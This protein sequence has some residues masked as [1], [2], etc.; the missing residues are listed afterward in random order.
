MAITT[1]IPRIKRT[2]DPQLID[3][4]QVKVIHSSTILLSDTYNVLLLYPCKVCVVSKTEAY[5]FHIVNTAY[6]KHSIEYIIF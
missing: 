5:Q 6:C 3:M 2:S 1:F 4:L